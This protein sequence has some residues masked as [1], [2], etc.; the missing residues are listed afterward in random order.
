MSK[1]K[2]LILYLFLLLGCSSAKLGN[3]I[4]LLDGDRLEDRIIVKCTGW[5]FNDCIAGTYL[6]PRSYNDHFDSHGHYAAY[7]E[8]AK[9]NR[10]WIIAK[11]IQVKDKKESYWIISKD[12]KINLDNCDKIN[13]DSIIQSHVTGPLSLNEFK[14]KI[15]GLNINLS[16]K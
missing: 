16:F 10:N 3:G 11:T 6:I 9:S 8:T 1:N 15:K 4:Y 5:S 14:N 2:F 7:V 13:C 12:F